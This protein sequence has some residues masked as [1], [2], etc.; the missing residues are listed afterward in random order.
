MFKK[1]TYLDFASTTPTPGVVLD[2]MNDYYKNYR[3]NVHRGIYDTSVKA[4]E[5]YEGARKTVAEFINADPSEII[6]TSGTTHSLN[7]LAYSLSPRLS[8]RDNV[9]LT[10]WEHH[11]NLVPWQQMARHYGFEIRYI[12]LENL[13]VISSEA[14]QPTEKSLSVIDANTKI[15]SFS[16]VSNVLGTIA[17]APEIIAAAKKVKAITIVDAAQA[18]AHLPLDVKQLDCDFLAFSGHKMYGPT[19]I[20][21]L[22]GKK[23]ILTEHLEPFFFGGEMV[24]SVSYEKAE[25]NDVPYKFEAGT[26]NIAGAIGQG[27]A[28]KYIQSIGW[29]KIQTHEQELIG[30]I[31][32]NLTKI[33]A[34]MINPFFTRHSE[35]VDSHRPTPARSTSASGSRNDAFN[36]IALISFTIPS[37]HPHDIAEVLN[38]DGIAVRAGFHCAEPLHRHLGLNQGT[39]RVSLGY[40]TTKKDIDKLVRALTKAKRLFLK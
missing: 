18:V 32:D 27:A 14:W 13:T 10:R 24:K 31:M 20:G 12:E 22:Y 17:S 33:G 30:M 35:E 34:Q 6:F 36:K 40:N 7:Q 26:P 25:W 28:V 29:E 9:V 5:A 2:A 15:V 3:A 23:E 21:V 4:T 11:A 8:H 19:G 38:R 39:V 1:N 16:L 37:T